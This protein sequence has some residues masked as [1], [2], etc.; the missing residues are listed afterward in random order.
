MC[1]SG[2][3]DKEISRL[4][5]SIHNKL[6]ERIDSQ[7]DS[8]FRTGYDAFMMAFNK[9]GCATCREYNFEEFEYI[10]D[11]MEVGMDLMAMSMVQDI[12][13]CDIRRLNMLLNLKLRLGVNIIA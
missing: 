10:L 4:K 7:L 8:L 11:S 12:P 6:R 13:N 5:R 1:V 3:L 2:I 9:I